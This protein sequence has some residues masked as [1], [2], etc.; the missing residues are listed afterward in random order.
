MLKR[1]QETAF[2]DSSQ[3]SN[4]AVKWLETCG[5]K[6]EQAILGKFWDNAGK[7]IRMKTADGSIGF[8]RGVRR[9]QWSAH[10]HL[11]RQRKGAALHL[12]GRPVE[13]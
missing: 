11:G 1:G 5:F 9:P 10:Q 4:A 3:A 12:R 13:G 8:P 2:E 6:A 7:P